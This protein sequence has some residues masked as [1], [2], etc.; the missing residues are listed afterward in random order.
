MLA[1]YG[2][3][4]RFRIA[5]CATDGLVGHAKPLKILEDQDEVVS[6]LVDRCVVGVS[7]RERIGLAD[8]LIEADLL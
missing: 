8:L 3:D 1:G 7:R 2:I 5:R 6:G 4:H